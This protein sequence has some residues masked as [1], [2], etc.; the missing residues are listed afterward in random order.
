MGAQGQ[1]S[2]V[3]TFFFLLRI[4][5]NFIKN[6]VLHL[7]K[8]LLQTLLSFM[9]CRCSWYCLL[10][11]CLSWYLSNCVLHVKIIIVDWFVQVLL[12]L[13]WDISISLLFIR[14]TKPSISEP[15]VIR[16][17]V[18]KPRV[19]SDYIR[20]DEWFSFRFLWSPVANGGYDE[21]C[22]HHSPSSLQS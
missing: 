22:S 2:L 16:P 21:P 1:R 7:N 5:T 4:I 18:F 19:K 14:V 3:M 9:F 10:R 20:T 11:H 15:C 6:F 8:A 13:I 12:Y 17:S